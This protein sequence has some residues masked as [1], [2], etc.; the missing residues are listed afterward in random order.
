MYEDAERKAEKKRPR[1]E[2]H[3]EIEKILNDLK[4]K[5]DKQLADEIESLQAKHAQDARWKAEWLNPLYPLIQ[6]G[7]LAIQCG[8]KIIAVIETLF[9]GESALCAPPEAEKKS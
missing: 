5:Y 1:G 7:K 2:R 6:A 4:L 8:K 3:R 9:K